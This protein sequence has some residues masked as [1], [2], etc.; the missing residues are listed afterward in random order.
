M[1]IKVDT[2]EL[3]S[4]LNKIDKLKL[5][6]TDLIS[7]S[8]DGFKHALFKACNYCDRLEMSIT[9]LKVQAIE[10]GTVLIPYYLVKML[11]QQGTK[12]VTIS[13]KELAWDNGTIEIIQEQKSNDFKTLNIKDS[14][15]LFFIYE[16]ELYR[17]L[18]NVSYSAAK[19]NRK[20]ILMGVNFKGNKVTAIDGYRMTICESDGIDVKIPITLTP[21]LVKVLLRV[22][23]KKSK[24]IVHFILDKTGKYVK[25]RVS[26]EVITAKLLEDEYIKYENIIPK[27]FNYSFVIENPKEFLN[28]V[29]AMYNY[30]SMKQ[31]ILML[32][33]TEGKLKIQN[34]TQIAAINQNLSVKNVTG[35]K[36]PFHI[37]VN[38]K[39]LY[40]PLK[41]NGGEI[42]IKFIDSIAPIIIT[43]DKDL[44]LVLPIRMADMEEGESDD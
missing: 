3:K 6:N 4:V 9:L 34:N 35:T 8:V 32:E 41:K 42:T 10:D 44:D 2:L 5:N 27:D 43:G 31:K 7:V 26:F 18:K 23:D 15:E 37:A 22:L 20:P 1:K 25:I 13:D 16:E 40:D 29:K 19:D 24:R 33:L 28:K 30:N 39:Y 21:E 11:A 17:V 12:S 38:P 36:F 14:D